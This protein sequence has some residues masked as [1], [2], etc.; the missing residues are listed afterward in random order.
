MSG[1]TYTGVFEIKQRTTNAMLV[2]DVDSGEEVWLPQVPDRRNPR[3]PGAARL[4]PHRHGALARGEEGVDHVIHS[5]QRTDSRL[6]TA[7]AYLRARGKYVV[8]PGCT[9]KPTPATDRF[10]IIQRY[11]SH[12]DRSR[13][14]RRE[15]RDRNT[16]GD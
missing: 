9:F 10:S 14:L 6:Q 1:P 15:G 12:G 7:I 4:Q 16:V 3:H 5:D 2:V 8:D 13:A 11:G